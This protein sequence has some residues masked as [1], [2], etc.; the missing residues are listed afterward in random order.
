MRS[1]DRHALKILLV[2][3]ALAVVGFAAAVYAQVCCLLFYN[4]PG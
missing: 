1:T 2:I 3:V 4:G